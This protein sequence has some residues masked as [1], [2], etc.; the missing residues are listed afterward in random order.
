MTDSEAP[1]TPSEQPEEDLKLEKQAELPDDL[2]V[3]EAEAEDVQAGRAPPYVPVGP[4]F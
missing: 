1:E 3:E 2:P 4:G